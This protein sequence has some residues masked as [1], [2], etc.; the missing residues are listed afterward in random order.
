MNPMCMTWGVGDFHLTGISLQ[1]SR[2]VKA[3]TFYWDKEKD[4]D[5]ETDIPKSAIKGLGS[6]FW[7]SIF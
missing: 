5:G 3:I 6:S 7:P 4:G 1:A 2:V